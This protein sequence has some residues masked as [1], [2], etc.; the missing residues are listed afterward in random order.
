M[1][2]SEKI[3]AAVS[4]AALCLS[5][6]P[7]AYAVS[8]NTGNTESGTYVTVLVIAG[9]LIIAAIVAGIVTKKKK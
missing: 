3:S 6:A 9:V 8:P 7:C 5:C 4:S 1:K 2:I